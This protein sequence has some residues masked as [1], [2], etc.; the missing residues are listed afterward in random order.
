MLRGKNQNAA[1]SLL[2]IYSL[3][4][5]LIFSLSFVSFLFLYTF[6]GQ[7]LQNNFFSIIQQNKVC[8]SLTRAVFL[9]YLKPDVRG[10][11]HL[12]SFVSLKQN[13]IRIQKENQKGLPYFTP[14]AGKWGPSPLSGSFFLLIISLSLRAVLKRQFIPSEELPWK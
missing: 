7:T 8:R 14:F 4:S 3:T 10:I 1:S 13:R 2:S 6:L 9:H 12:S 5:K 11:L